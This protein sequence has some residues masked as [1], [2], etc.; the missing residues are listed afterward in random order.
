M[1]MIINMKIII[2]NVMTKQKVKYAKKLGFQFEYKIIESIFIQNT[3][4]GNT[5]KF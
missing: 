3:T 5:I 4:E 2:R 1:K